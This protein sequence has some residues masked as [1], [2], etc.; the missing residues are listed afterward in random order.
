MNSVANYLL[1]Q[2][3]AAEK[4]ARQGLK[5]DIEGSIPKLEY[6]LGMVLLRKH[7]LAGAQ[8]HMKNYVQRAPNDPDIGKVQQQLAA[9]EKA[10][11][12]PAAT[13]AAAPRN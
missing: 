3:D 8:E 6:V 9:L 11:G 4:S 10:T 7:D 5:A 12:T 2:F 13:P 1:N